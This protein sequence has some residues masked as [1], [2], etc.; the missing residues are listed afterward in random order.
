MVKVPSIDAITGDKLTAFAPNTIGIPYFKGKDQ[1]PFSME[2]CKQLFD[3][4]KLFEQIKNMEIVSESFKAFAGYEI[5][6]RKSIN[7]DLELTP[8]KVLKD[9]IDTCALLTKR[10]SA[11]GNETALFKEL[12]RGIIAFGTGYLMKGTFR[13]DNAIQAAARIACLAAKISVNDFSPIKYYDEQD[14]SKLNIESKDWSFLNKLKR[15]PDKSGFFYWH[16]AINL[17]S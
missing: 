12:Q 14:I 15:Q 8:D 10:H 3:L 13:I 16:Q 5:E 6:Y 2:I 7:P 1:Q 9:T 17:I 4:S 11:T